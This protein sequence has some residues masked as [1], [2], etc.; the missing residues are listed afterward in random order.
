MKEQLQLQLRWI[1]S[2][3]SVTPYPFEAEARVNNI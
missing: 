1:I 3:S 2:R